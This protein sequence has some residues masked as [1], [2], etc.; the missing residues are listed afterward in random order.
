MLAIWATA[1]PDATLRNRACLAALD[2]ERAVDRFNQSSYTE[3]K[4]P[5]RIGLHSG[6]MLLGNIGAID[7]YEY[8]PVGDI[9]NTV[10][11]IEGLNKILGTR[12]LVSE[13]VLYQVDGF[14]TRELGK[15][16][17]FGKS[18]PTV[19]YELICRSE[20]SNEQKKG[21]CNIF[22]KALCAYRKQ[23]W[24]EAIKILNECIKIRKE[25]GPSRFYLKRCKKYRKNP[26]GEMW[27]GIVR[28]DK[29]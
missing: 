1:H 28:L 10:S 13:D 7:H 24:E 4:L 19:V 16:L 2:I 8:R 29:K 6:Q 21:I 18:K 3:E 26:P 12:I 20:E 5:T 23:S 22:P 9:V 17:L 14:L 25:D 11:R 27:D 15:F